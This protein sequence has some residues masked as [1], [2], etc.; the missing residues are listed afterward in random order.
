MRVDRLKVFQIIIYITTLIIVTRLFYWQFL[1]NVTKNNDVFAQES[2]LPA[3][4]GEI[5]ASDGFPLVTNQE[6]FLLY[7]QPN[8]LAGDPQTIASKLAPYLISEKYSTS[9]AQLS[10]E[11]QKQKDQ[12]I[13]DK[14][15]YLAQKLSDKKLFWVQL[16]RKIPLQ[17]KDKINKF[18][19]KGLDFERDTKRF[20]P[21]ASMSAQLLGF[22]GADKFGDDTGYFGLEGY[23]DKQLRGQDGRLGEEKDPFGFPILV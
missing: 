10:E 15:Q 19:L 7:G 2:K 14:Q 6:A 1:A 20:Y 18:S 9:S 16:A 13:K 23:Y 4:R 17:I 12:E 22:V 3:S 21:E 5:Y 8:E 11:E